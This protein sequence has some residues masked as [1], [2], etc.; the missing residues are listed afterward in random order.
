MKN[1]GFVVVV[2]VRCFCVC[3]FQVVV[4]ISINLVFFSVVMCSVGLLWMVV[5]LWMFSFMLLI[6]IELVD[7]I[8]QVWWLLVSMQVVFL[9]VFS[10]VFSMWVLVCRGRVLVFLV[11]LLVSV[12]N[13]FECLLCGNGL[14]FYDGG[15]LVLV[16]MIQIW[17][18]CV[19]FGFR[20]YLLW[21]MLLFVFIICMLFVFVWFML[22]RL[23]WWVMVFLCIQ[24]MIFMLL[25]ECGGKLVFGVMVLLFYMCSVFQFIC[26]GLWQLVN[27]KWC[28]VLSQLWLV[29]L[30]LL[31]GLCLIIM[32]FQMEVLVGV[33]G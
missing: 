15:L 33:M 21:V 8:R 10:V 7:G 9:L 28:L 32:F 18:I 13:L 2:F 31:K 11:K 12:M 17:K 25:C 24:V 22:F 30:R 5:L 26:L 14:V 4:F 27:E 19:V 29:L 1:G 23:L 6:L 20:L 3:V 16:G